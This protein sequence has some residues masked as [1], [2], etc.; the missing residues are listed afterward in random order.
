MTVIF[1]PDAYRLNE[2]RE[3][4]SFIYSSIP[5][6]IKL[7][8]LTSFTI[9]DVSKWI[10][11]RGVHKIKI[12]DRPEAYTSDLYSIMQD[13]KNENTLYRILRD[14]MSKLESRTK[15]VVSTKYTKSGIGKPYCEFDITYKVPYTTNDVLV[16]LTA[17]LAFGSLIETGISRVIIEFVKGLLTPSIISSVSLIISVITL[18][19]VKNWR[20]K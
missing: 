12:S 1:E 9:H 6:W 11:I 8:P 5:W 16:I 3:L 18:C 4:P 15:Q 20:H 7:F 13:S 17:V 19:V 10:Q 2:H 14:A